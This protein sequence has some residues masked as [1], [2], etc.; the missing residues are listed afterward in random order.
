MKTERNSPC[1]CNSGKKH[2]RCCGSV[3]A[4][5]AA[6]QARRE[7]WKRQ[8]EARRQRMLELGRNPSLSSFAMVIAATLA[9]KRP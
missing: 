5:E 4:Q 6:L 7:Q 8:E 2:K 3:E 9:M 1:P